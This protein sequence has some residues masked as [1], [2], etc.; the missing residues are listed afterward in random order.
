MPRCYQILYRGTKGIWLDACAF[1]IYEGPAREYF[2][3]RAL[4]SSVP[5]ILDCASR[6]HYY[7][8]Q[9]VLGTNA[10]VLGYLRSLAEDPSFITLGLLCYLD[11]EVREPWAGEVIRALEAQGLDEFGLENCSLEQLRWA[12]RRAFELKRGDLM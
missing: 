11:E 3:D 1:R 6:E 8:K 7:R 5:L 4:E 9:E 10:L 2:V 12:A